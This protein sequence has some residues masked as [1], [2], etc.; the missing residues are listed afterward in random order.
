MTLFMYVNL[1]HAA[2]ANDE[3]EFYSLYMYILPNALKEK[4]T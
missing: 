4:Y 1:S 3:V 2:L